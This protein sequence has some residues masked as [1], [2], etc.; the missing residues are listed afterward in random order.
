M[1]D[2][3]YLDMYVGMMPF[4]AEV[5]GPGCEIVV[6][7][8]THPE[9]SI[10]AIHN[11]STGRQLGD[12]LTDLFRDII[13]EGRYH[14]RDYLVGYRGC[15]KDKEFL[16]FTYFIKNEGRLI[17][18]LCVNKDLSLVNGFA[19]KLQLMLEK[20]SLGSPQTQDTQE[21]L[22]TSVTDMLRNLVSNAI[23]QT[24]ITPGRM[25]MEEKVTLVHRLNE[26]GVL[27]MKGSVAEIAGQLNISEPT[28]YRYLN[29]KPGV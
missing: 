15:T 7:D 26:Q 23:L 19:Q 5:C 6:H 8:I 9:H 21:N 24:G 20:F 17:G 14:N 10:V 2:K 12:P 29:R 25:S 27:S 3:K 28:V 22:D 11:C 16:S 1:T 4:W 18:L 13:E